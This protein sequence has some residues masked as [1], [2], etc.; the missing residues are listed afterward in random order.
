[1]VAAPLPAGSRASGRRVV[2]DHHCVSRVIAAVGERQDVRLAEVGTRMLAILRSL[3]DQHATGFVRLTFEEA[4][5]V[6]ASLG[7]TPSSPSPR[8]PTTT[9]WWR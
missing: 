5:M 1:M 6:G 3:E 7:G 9:S 4:A 2:L 8:P